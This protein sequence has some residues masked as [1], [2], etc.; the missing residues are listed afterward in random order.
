MKKKLLFT[1]L[2]LV[3]LIIFHIIGAGIMNKESILRNKHDKLSKT[4]PPI[5]TPDAEFIIGAMDVGR[6]TNNTNDYIQL[7]LNA[8]HQYTGYF[9]DGFPIDTIDN[10]DTD[11]SVYRPKL[12][13][14]IDKNR[15]SN[16]YRTIMGRPKIEYLALG[17][18]SD[19]QCERVH[20]D[21]DYGF[22]TYDTSEITSHIIDEED[23]SSFGNGARVKH[24][25]PNSGVTDGGATWIVKGL[26][27]NREQSNK[28]WNPQQ[29]DDTWEWYV[30]PRIRIPV[31][32][33]ANTLICKIEIRDWN[34]NIVETR[35]ILAGNFGNSQ[36]PYNGQYMEQFYFDIVN[37]NLKSAIRIPPGSICPGSE[38]E[39]W[40]WD[41][42]NIYTDYKVYW[43]GQCE[44]WIDYV[45]VENKPAHDLLTTPTE[46]ARW[47]DWLQQE[48]DIANRNYDPNFPIPNNF[49]TEEYE[50]NMLP[51]IRRVNEI[52]QQRSNN[53]LS[54]MV[55]LNYGLFKIHVPDD[56]PMSSEQISKY[57]IEGTSG[58]RTL[59]S[60]ACPLG[61]FFS[62]GDN[63]LYV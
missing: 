16:N 48:A 47:T 22:Y 31:N 60:G 45:R 59:V 14:F 21:P 44:M 53:R 15:D 30:M 24:C 37:P 29:R 61:G 51:S 11:P 19:Y 6:K 63:L 13:P 43:Y 36:H 34:N 41:T 40:N 26:K 39:F 49:Y 32:M 5:Q 2:I 10:Y 27:A 57:L 12:E 42:V 35:D 7:K 28:I 56:P 23:Y 62:P 9:N 3:P 25:I 4:I 33:A 46:M 18:R 50:F 20:Q 58:I 1:A 55:A 17:Q 8:W 52:I 38:K 54:L